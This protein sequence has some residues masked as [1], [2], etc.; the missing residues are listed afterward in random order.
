MMGSAPPTSG[1]NALAI[2]AAASDPERAKAYIQEIMKVTQDMQ[3]TLEATREENIKAEDIKRQNEKVLA[4]IEAN[5]KDLDEKSKTFN[6]QVLVK[7]HEIEDLNVSAT[8]AKHEADMTLLDAKNT[9]KEAD[10]RLSQVVARETAV[11]QRET[12]LDNRERDVSARENTVNEKYQ[13][14]SAIING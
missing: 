8:A 4:E 3:N 10:Q 5:Q 13:K 11:K 6:S 14:L 2:L 1:D 7:M 9:S 12:D